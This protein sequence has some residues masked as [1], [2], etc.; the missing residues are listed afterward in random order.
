MTET[1]RRRTQHG[2]ANG[3]RSGLEVRVAEQISTAG[4]KVEYEATKV[5]FM[6]PEKSRYY[7]PDFILPNGIVVETK[8]RFMTADRQKHKWVKEQHP[9]LEIRFVFSRAAQRLSKQSPTTYGAWCH[10]HGFQYADLL[11]PSFWLAE[12]VNDTWVAAIKEAARR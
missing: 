2:I 12:P 3:Y 9:N 10:Q 5:H 11:I 7:S 4:I 1:S 8:G 6:Q